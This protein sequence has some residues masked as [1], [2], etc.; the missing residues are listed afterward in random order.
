MLKITAA[1]IVVIRQ[2]IAMSDVQDPAIYLL[3][4]S[5]L[6]PISKEESEAIRSGADDATLRAALEKDLA[7]STPPR[8][9]LKAVVYPSRNFPSGSLTEIQ[10]IRFFLPPEVLRDEELTLDLRDQQLVLLDKYGSIVT[11]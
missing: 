2:A 10:G 6:A 9:R 1:A 8:Y 4:V 7:R 11:W 5:R 3:E